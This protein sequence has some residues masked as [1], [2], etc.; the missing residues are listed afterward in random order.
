MHQGVRVHSPADSRR[1]VV[2]VVDDDLSIRESLSHLLEELKYEVVLAE[3]GHDAL[4]LLRARSVPPSLILLD[5]MMPVM[6]GWQFL[7]ERQKDSLLSSIPLVVIS[8]AL[9]ASAELPDVAGY[10]KKPVASEQLVGMLEH[11]HSGAPAGG[12][13]RSPLPVRGSTP[14]EGPSEHE[15]RPL[16]VLLI[17]ENDRDARVTETLLGKGVEF[18]FEVRRAR[19][20]SEGFQKEAL[21]EADVILLDMSLS[22]ETGLGPLQKTVRHA[23]GVPL[24]VFTTMDS[25]EA[26]EETLQ[27]GAQDAL[28]KELQS[29][30][31]LGR[32]LH[33]A[34]ER[35]RLR[36]ELERA[37]E[38]AAHERERRGLARW[39]Q[40]RLTVSAEMLGQSPLKRA[41]PGGFQ[42]FVM[43]FI[44]ICETAIANRGYEIESSA[45]RNALQRLSDALASLRVG[46]GD[47]VDIYQEALS[48]AWEGENSEVGVAKREEARLMLIGM[49]GYVLASYRLYVGPENPVGSST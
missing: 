18:Q 6:N 39:A 47:I 8:A 15:K 49:L 16:R 7:E 4:A 28:A 21:A 5:L 40:P 10:L 17:Q 45:Q 9:D 20:L 30:E 31:L 43:E 48:K 2:L 1:G 3:N 25:K 27:K 33:H 35:H 36:A 14:N 12:T 19:N 38:V 41:S 23:P 13:T 22:G 11:L 42:K 34:F 26:R 44:A 46:P 29:P 32:S 24:V 37:R